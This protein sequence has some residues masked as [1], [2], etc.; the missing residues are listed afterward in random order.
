MKTDLNFIP[1]NVRRIY[2]IAVCGT[3]M[4]A[5]ACMLKESGYEVSG[6][7]RQMYPPVNLLLKERGIHL[8]EGF[9]PDHLSGGYDLVVVGNA[10]RSDNPEAVKMREMRLPFCSMPQAINHFA[11]AGRKSLVITGTHG[12]TTTSSLLAWILYCAGLDPT[13]IIGGI[14][15][16]FGSNFRTGSGPY[17]VLEGDEYDTA[18]FD[19]GSKFLHYDPLI[20]ILTSIEFDHADIFRSERDVRNAFEKFISKMEP[21]S[22]LLAYD[23]DSTVS[24]LTRNCRCRV[25]R[26]GLNPSS[27]W[28]LGNYT[29]AAPWTHFE[30][31]KNGTSWGQFQTRMIGE[32]NLWNAVSTIAAADMLDVPVSAIAE[33]MKTFEGVRRRQDIRGCKNGITV[34]DDFAHHP[35]AVRETLRAV[36]PFYP[37]GRIIAVFEPR[38][39][40]SMRKVFQKDYSLSFDGADMVCIRHPSLLDKIPPDERF[41]SEL[42]VHDLVG[43][44]MDAHFFQDT[45]AIIDFLVKEAKPGDL[46][47]IMSNGGFDQIHERLLT[48]L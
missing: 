32:H 48:A 1:E 14:L 33:A 15:K 8:L 7:D 44:G 23:Q 18:Y 2:L 3:G 29:V 40:S 9:D 42:L 4:G 30:V 38:T 12:K 41:S 11:G 27:P 45:D 46:V 16:N 10:V 6:S 43:R 31:N 19:K 5:L 13:Y 34:M 28:Q 35:T 47:L 39:H 20:A 36:R 26:Y 21:S 37:N 25:D 17:I 22:V 24:D